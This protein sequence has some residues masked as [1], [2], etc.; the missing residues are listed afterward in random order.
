MED[1]RTNLSEKLE[2]L[3]EKVVTT[4]ESATTAV[5]DT[6]ATVT[7]AVQGTVESVKEGV[8]GAVETVKETFNLPR[9]VER[10]PWA[11]FAGAA[12]VGF[13][14]GKLLDLLPRGGHAV[15]RGMSAA[16]A[17][18]RPAHPPSEDGGKS[19]LRWLAEAFG[20][21]IDQVK[22]LAVGAALG[23]VRD[24]VAKAVPETLG[25]QI[26]D[27]I[28]SFTTKVGGK[29][30]PGPVLPEHQASGPTHGPAGA[31]L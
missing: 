5:A 21:E 25:P 22:G 19:W 27:M 29:P 3:Q 18:A 26:K 30:V 14:A 12:A 6:V 31:D 7:D 4:V 24:L 9:Q 13:A 10:H 17:P 16:A 2:T 1:T 28:D 20:P 8:G 23:L 15:A 11:M